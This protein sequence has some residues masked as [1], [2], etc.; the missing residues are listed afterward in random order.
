MDRSYALSDLPWPAV[1]AH[2]E[3]DR[4]LIIPVGA[5]DPQ[6]PHLPIGA[7]TCVA[8]ALARDLSQEFGVLRAPSF[9][10]GV[11]LPGEGVYPGTASL[12]TKTLHRALNELL[13]SWA[14]HGFDEFIAITANAHA[15]HAEAVA[16]VRAP[17]ARVRVV[18]A[19][20]VDVSALL[21][22]ERGPEHAG[23]VMTSLLLH[24]R[25]GCVRKEQAK[26]YTM[27]AAQ[28]SRLVGGRLRRVPAA[29]GGAVGQPTLATAEKGQRIYEHILQKIRL[30]VFIAPLSRRPRRRA[31]R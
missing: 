1:A 26:D 31:A 15:P 30:K 22:G 8:E 16:T 6:G 17:G 20:T 28:R 9:H 27:E 23:E 12:R 14:A 29:S 21:D 19:L 13:H 24:L 3:R 11:N 4:R 25:A 10:Y 2:L 18:E 5:C 7:G